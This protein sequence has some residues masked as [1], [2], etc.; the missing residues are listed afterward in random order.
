MHIGVSKLTIIGSNNG[1]SPGQ[2]QAIIWTIAGI[3]LIGPLWINF[4]DILIKIHT[5]SFR[6]MHLKMTSGKWRPSCL[7]LKVFINA[8]DAIPCYHW[9]CYNHPNCTYIYTKQITISKKKWDCQTIDLAG[10]NMYQTCD[11]FW[12]LILWLKCTGP[13]SLRQQWQVAMTYGNQTIGIQ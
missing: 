4:S 13:H 5:F 12:V 2:R 3:L 8:L 11:Q 9:P 7:G 10:W 1:L 6:K